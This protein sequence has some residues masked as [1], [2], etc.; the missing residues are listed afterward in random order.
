MNILTVEGLTKSYGEKV[1]FDNI[2]FG[3]DS[4]DKIGIIGVNG[5]GKSTLLKIIA[6][7]DTADSGTVTTMNGI[8]IG[9][10][11]QTPVFNEAEAVI[12]YMDRICNLSDDKKLSEAKSVLTRLG[13]DDYYKLISELSGGQRKRVALAA[14]MIAPVDLL[15]LDEPTNHIDNETVDWIENNMKSA[16]KALLMVTHDRYF[17]DR[18][19][20]KTIELDKGRLYTY[21]GNYSEFLVKKA[22]REEL[23]QSGE[24]KRQSFLRTELEWIRRGARARTTKQ[25]ARIERFEEISHVKAPTQTQSIEINGVAS[26]LG[27]KT[28]EAVGISKAYNNVAYV[29]DFS[30]IVLKDDRI[31]IVGKNGAGKSTLLNML[32]CRLSPDNGS[33]VIGE[34]VKIG[35]FSQENNEMPQ[36][37]RVI[38]YVKDFGEY[39][40]TSKGKLS[41]SQLLEKFVFTPDMQYS[42]ISKLSGGEKR[43]LYLLTVL[44]SAPNILFL[45]EP[46]NDLDIQTLCILED[47]LDGFNGP[48]VIVSH[49]RYFLDRCVNRIFSFEGN[50]YIKQYEGNYSD[51]IATKNIN[52]VSVKSEA[53]VKEKKIWD[54]GEKKLKMSYNEQREMETID[55]EIAELENALEKIDIKIQEASASYSVLQELLA[56]KEELEQKLSYKMDRWV[57]LTELAEKIGIQ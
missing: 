4:K 32:S 39:I 46:T 14:A 38:D 43:R 20:N 15:I 40:E 54:K 56:E 3:I 7:E 28:I 19:V 31:G 23:E 21:E 55:D 13:I 42:P 44:M 45:D 11:P 25:K 17:L 47:Y 5:T 48:V 26:R 8:K 22:E 1:I 10:L 33:V 49:D 53:T 18:M 51:Y 57:Y 29:K 12:D 27:K 36:D 6:G 41:A 9:Y 16:T 24:R 30:Y 50:G 34:T 35:F 2:S 37:K 52:A